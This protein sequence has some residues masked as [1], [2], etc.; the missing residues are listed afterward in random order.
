MRVLH[1]G[2][3]LIDTRDGRPCHVSD[4]GPGGPLWVRKRIVGSERYVR[5]S[6]NAERFVRATIRERA[7][8]KYGLRLVRQAETLGLTYRQAWEAVQL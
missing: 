2:T 8:K 3:E 1:I 7:V 4:V 5:L 6:W